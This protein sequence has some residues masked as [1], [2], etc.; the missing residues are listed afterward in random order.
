MEATA[1]DI[2][3]TFIQKKG[4]NQIFRTDNHNLDFLRHQK[5]KLATC[6]STDR[7]LCCSQNAINHNIGDS[8]FVA[9]FCTNLGCNLSRC[10]RGRRPLGVTR[11]LLRAVREQIQK[12]RMT[13]SR[14][15]AK[16]GKTSKSGNLF[17]KS[18]SK[19]SNLFTKS[20]VTSS[21]RSKKLSSTQTRINC[22]WYGLL[23]GYDFNDVV[24]SHTSF[25]PL[26]S[27]ALLNVT[28]TGSVVACSANRYSINNF[29]TPSLT[30]D[31]FMSVEN[32]NE[33]E[34]LPASMHYQKYS[35]V[36]GKKRPVQQDSKNVG[37]ESFAHSARSIVGSA[38]LTWI[39][40][41]CL[42]RI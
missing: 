8:S 35:S 4:G 27:Y 20:G 6:A 21:S 12:P 9:N 41:V 2:E 3:L 10:G 24:W 11:H 36:V 26:H 37:K 33:N 42:L 40:I 25:Q 17:A 1:L 7:A 38:I 31:K 28:D 32:C 5:R 34:D 15:S 30:C 13:L 22:S 29:D 23:S 16:A 39:F 14:R 18:F 19:S